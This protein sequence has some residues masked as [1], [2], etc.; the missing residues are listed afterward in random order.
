MKN[1]GRLKQ[2]REQNVSSVID[3]P[4]KLNQFHDDLMKKTVGVAV[5]NVESEWGLPPAHFA[6]FIMGSAGRSEQSIWSDQDHGI[7]FEGSDEN[8][9]YFLRL[10]EEI[11]EALS[12]VGY[13]YCDGKVMA[14][15]P[16]WCKSL[17]SWMKQIESWLEIESWESLRYFST[18]FDSR[19]LIG[20]HNFLDKLKRN[21]FIIL[22][23]NP[24]LYIRLIE[25]VSHLRKGIGV[26]GQLLPAM[27]GEETGQLN[28]KEKVF[29]AYVN[30]LRLLAL[31]EKI[32]APDTLSR[33]EQL[34]KENYE[35]IMKYRNEFLKLLHY[36]LHFQ[37]DAKN[38][39]KVHL[40]N[41]ERLSKQEK[42]E[43]KQIMKRGYKLFSET[44][45]MIEKDVRHGN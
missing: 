20:D 40:L 18:F 35:T 38:Y 19:V 7:I 16:L 15:N 13:D 6:F 23:Q 5:K 41:V 29:F 43:L 32:L 24:N 26:F 36:R 33:F 25:N 11:T 30:S 22:D 44:K 42:Q 21:A 3:D 9:E 1:Y 8:Q 31:K 14:S 37:K 39:E 4:Q 28:I 34:P 27:T 2:W 10:G 45:A 17:D 12:H